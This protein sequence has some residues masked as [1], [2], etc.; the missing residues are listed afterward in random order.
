M[1]LYGIKENYNM[2]RTQFLKNLLVGGLSVATGGKVLAKDKAKYLTFDELFIV[3]DGNSRLIYPRKESMVYKELE[4]SFINRLDLSK[5]HKYLPVHQ[6]SI[7][8]K[9]KYTI[10]DFLVVK[11][12]FECVY[13]KND[14]YTTE[15]YGVSYRFIKNGEDRMYLEVFLV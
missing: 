8:I 5:H 2:N 7:S 9:E 12:Y 14:K 6:V 4:K 10:E 3:H 11:Y 15:G 1:F 13:A